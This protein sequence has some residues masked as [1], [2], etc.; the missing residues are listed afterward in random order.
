MIESEKIAI[1]EPMYETRQGRNLSAAGRVRS[2]LRTTLYRSMP[3][4]RVSPKFQVVIPREVREAMG[5]V[6]GQQVE[7][8]LHDGRIEII[9]LNP[10]SEMRGFAKGI[11]TTVVREPDREL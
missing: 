8:I 9:P 7:V 11:D 2:S 10:L 4:V 5:L 6:P 3:S 1:R